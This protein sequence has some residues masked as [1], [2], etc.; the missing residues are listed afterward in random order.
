MND[1]GRVGRTKGTPPPPHSS[2]PSPEPGGSTWQPG[3]SAR[4][5]E[6]GTWAQARVGQQGERSG[7][8]NKVDEDS[9]IFITHPFPAVQPRAAL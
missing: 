7:S 8:L 1:A 2:G 9:R 3:T 4:S 5:S 6:R